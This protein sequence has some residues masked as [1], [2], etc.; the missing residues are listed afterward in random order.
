[1]G[2]QAFNAKRID[3]PKTEQSHP[4]KRKRFAIFVNVSWTIVAVGPAK[5]VTTAS[6]RGMVVT[7][8]AD[9]VQ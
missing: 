2:L 7:A 6:L 5:F 3:G 4:V 1:L 8:V 9:A